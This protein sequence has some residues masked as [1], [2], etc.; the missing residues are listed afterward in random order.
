MSMMFLSLPVPQQLRYQ[1]LQ[2]SMQ[3]ML[4]SGRSPQTHPPG[5]TCWTGRFV[6]SLAQLVAWPLAAETR[7]HQPHLESMITIQVW[8]RASR[9][10][11]GLRSF[12]CN[13]CTIVQVYLPVYHSIP[14]YF[15]HVLLH[16]CCSCRTCVYAELIP[17]KSDVF[18]NHTYNLQHHYN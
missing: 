17:P 9:L 11:C 13:L 16:L 7:V 18:D 14:L 5:N 12:G 10:C 15:L 1:C 6:L 3:Y 4:F 8:W 2:I